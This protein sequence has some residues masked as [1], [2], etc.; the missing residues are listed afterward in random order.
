MGIPLN[1]TISNFQQKLTTKGVK[2]NANLSKIFPVGCRAFDGTFAGHPAE[3]YVYY[4]EKTKNVY[5]AKAVYSALS[6]D[7]C[8]RLYD[9]TKNSLTYKYSDA[10]T[11]SENVDGV[12]RPGFHIFTL[13]TNDNRYGEIDLYQSKDDVH[14]PYPDYYNLH[15]DYIDLQNYFAHQDKVSDDL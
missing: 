11:E 8:N 14:L 2:Y 12:S 9:E 13:D 4:D 10:E 3:I 15:I 6:E 7:Y 1:G 5:R